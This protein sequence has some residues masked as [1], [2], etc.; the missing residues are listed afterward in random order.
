[1]THAG[2]VRVLI[3]PYLR[4]AREAGV[5]VWLEAIS[6][7]GRQVYEHLSFRTAAEVRLG[8]G[9]VNG[10]GELDAHGEGLVVYGMIAE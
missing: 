8:V 5:P 10:D 3:D 6:D 2:V 1:M 9:R 7:H 4:K